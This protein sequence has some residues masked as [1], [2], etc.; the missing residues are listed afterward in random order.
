M[1]RRILLIHILLL[2]LRAIRET[3][4]HHLPLHLPLPCMYPQE[5]QLPGRSLVLLILR[6]ARYCRTWYP[7]DHNPWYHPQPIH[8][9][10]YPSQRSR[11]RSLCPCSQQIPRTIPLLIHAEQHPSRL[12]QAPPPCRPIARPHP[13]QRSPSSPRSL[14]KS[15]QGLFPGRPLPN[16]RKTPFL[17]SWS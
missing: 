13:V 2:I 6:C 10:Q 8:R 7:M 4:P 12:P 14:P 9:P 3:C 17:P 1:R 11:A 15:R 5:I 16:P